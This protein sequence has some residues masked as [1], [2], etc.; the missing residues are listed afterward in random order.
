LLL[1]A[2][3]VYAYCTYNELSYRHDS[4]ND[5]TIICETLYG[6]K[7]SLW[8]KNGLPLLIK[9][10]SICIT[11]ALGAVKS[12]EQLMA[13]VYPDCIRQG[14]NHV[15]CLRMLYPSMN[16]YLNFTVHPLSVTISTGIVIRLCWMRFTGACIE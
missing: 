3:D 14:A 11:A 4:T 5:D 16:T 6:M 8:L 13:K 9:H 15:R 10:C 12:I 1:H 2:D 7:L